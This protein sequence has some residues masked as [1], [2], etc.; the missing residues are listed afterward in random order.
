MITRI[1]VNDDYAGEEWWHH[2]RVQHA[3]GVAPVELAPLFTIGGPDAVDVPPDADPERVAAILRWCSTLRGWLAPTL[4][5][6]PALLFQDDAD[7]ALDTG[8]P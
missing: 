3:M 7:L 6:G 5:Q 8:N 2:A 1:S 4:W